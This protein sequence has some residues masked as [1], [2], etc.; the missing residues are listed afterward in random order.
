MLGRGYTR[1]ADAQLHA[2]I[3]HRHTGAADAILGGVDSTPQSTA[4]FHLKPWIQGTVNAP[5]LSAVAG[6]ALVL[7]ISY[8]SCTSDF[9]V[10][11]TNLSIP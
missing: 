8:L 1:A 5:P 7:H 10:L 6:D 9:T 2:D 3:I 11:E 4:D